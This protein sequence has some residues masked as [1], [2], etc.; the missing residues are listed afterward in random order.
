ME[1][2]RNAY[3]IVIRRPERERLLW[4]SSHRWD[5]NVTV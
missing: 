3:K 1:E 2:M 4:S 5:D